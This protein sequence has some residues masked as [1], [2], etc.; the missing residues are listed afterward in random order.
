MKLLLVIF[1]ASFVFCT[2]VHGNDDTAKA[3]NLLKKGWYINANLFAQYNSLGA[4]A[5]L[6][7]TWNVPLKEKMNMVWSHVELGSHMGVSPAATSVGVHGEWMPLA[8]L[9]L[10]LIYDFKMFH[11][12]HGSLLGIDSKSTPHDEDDM[13]RPGLGKGG[14][15]HRVMLYPVIQALYKGFLFRNQNEVVLYGVHIDSPYWFN[16]QIESISKPR[17]FILTERVNLM[18]DL[19]VKHKSRILFVGPFYSLAWQ[20]S[21]NFRRQR[22]GIG[23]YTEP[24]NNKGKKIVPHFMLI[25]GYNLEEHYR[26]HEFVFIL[27]AGFNIDKRRLQYR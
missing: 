12:T 7:A 11:G 24:F 9:R 10:R 26:R 15:G 25:A 20:P 27:N 3:Q 13:A 1:F 19:L 4:F 22:T 17:D 6:E 21:T 14:I 23:I 16:W 18:Y 2:N 8:L 5:L